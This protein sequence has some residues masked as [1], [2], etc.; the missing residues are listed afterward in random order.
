MHYIQAFCQWLNE[1]QWSTYLRESDYPFPIIE[2]FH[3][4]G[5]AVSVGVIMWLDLRFLNVVMRDEPIQSVVD[6]LEPW[7]MGGFAIMFVSGSLLFLSEPMKCYN[8]LAFRLKVI[9]LILTGL[10]VMYF[11]AKLYARLPEFD[12]LSS[13][14]WQ[15]KMVGIVS[16]VF[17]FGI[18]IAGRWTAYF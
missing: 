7:A 12:K 2:T 3:V 1:T 15:L 4:I 16:F 11:H 13:P 6:Q 14:P 18:I 8:T 5:L 10:N 17:W 9:M